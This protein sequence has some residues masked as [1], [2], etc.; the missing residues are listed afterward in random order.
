METPTLEVIF[1]TL[2]ENSSVIANDT[3]G[4]TWWL[5]PQLVSL[6]SGGTVQPEN[7]FLYPQEGDISG[8]TKPKSISINTNHIY[9]ATNSIHL[10]KPVSA[11]LRVLT[12][13]E[14]LENLEKGLYFRQ[15]WEN[16]EYVLGK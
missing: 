6:L 11:D 15:L 10:P 5:L 14:N 13:L 9:T 7:L 16:L 3:Q 1:V 2:T 8:L 12:D 4:P